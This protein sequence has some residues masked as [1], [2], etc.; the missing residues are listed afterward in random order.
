MNLELDLNIVHLKENNPASQ[1]VL[2]ANR[3]RLNKSCMKVLNLL[4]S[5]KE[6]TVRNAMV[7][8][9][10]SSLPRRIMDCEQ[11]LNIVIPERWVYLSGK[12]E[13]GV[14]KSHKV[15]FLDER[16]KVLIEEILEKE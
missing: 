13:N 11:K 6:L 16:S 8:Y 15:W 14:Y 2:N 7:D 10:I 1:A 4:M 12:P 5:G 9:G 3:D